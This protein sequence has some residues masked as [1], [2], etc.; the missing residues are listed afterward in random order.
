M[1]LTS[2][3]TAPL[4]A[5]LPTHDIDEVLEAPIHPELFVSRVDV[6]LER[7]R[8]ERRLAEARDGL[9]QQL[10]AAQQHAQQE[11][12]TT[13]LLLEAARTL[14]ATLDLTEV[15]TQLADVALKFTGLTRA[16][17]NLIDVDRQVLTPIVAT[18][19]L[20][21]PSGPSIP[22]D[23][24]SKTSM[25]AIAAKETALLDYELAE[26]PEYDRKIAEANNSKLVLFVPLLVGGEMV[27]HIALDEPGER[28]QFSEREIE[29]VARSRV[30]GRDRRPERPAL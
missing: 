14:G 23:R 21:A 17:V 9:V 10:R 30:A 2:A 28:H 15:L 22:F 27:G 8:R 7:R 13:R 11:L 16:F 29:L 5:E 3:R 26:T 19:G 18:G 25:K 12:E 4:V 24:L 20:A 1:L 6:L